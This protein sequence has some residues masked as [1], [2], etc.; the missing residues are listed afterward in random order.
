MTSCYVYGIVPAGAR[1][2]GGLAG[3]GG[4][5]CRL[6]S[7]AGSAPG[8]VISEVDA[9]R[10]LGTPADLRAHAG[11][12][13]A[14]AQTAPVLPMQFGA[15]LEDDSA[16]LE[17][18]LA[19]Y[20][21]EF[22]SRLDYL[23]GRDQFTVRG[24]YEDDVALREI[25]AEEPEIRRLRERLRGQDP[26][27]ARWENIRLGELVSDALERKR[28]ADTATLVSALAPHAADVADRVPQ[29][30]DT[31]ADLAFLVD[32]PRRREFEDAAQEAGKRWE[33]RVRLRLAGPLPP[34][35]FAQ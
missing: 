14:V 29:A 32:R 9:S 10:A 35:D 2:P 6:V 4:E 27:T 30:D 1:L 22:A 26:E 23:R 15:V 31:A 20:S 7:P 13:E 18:L 25:L 8:A 28:Q 33:G 3:L 34:Y 11:V 24:R 21:G 16:V 17:E 19:P 12:L 5:N